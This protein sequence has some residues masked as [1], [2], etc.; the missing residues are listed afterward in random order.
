MLIIRKL[1]CKYG[2]S[3]GN[4]TICIILIEFSRYYAQFKRLR[5][6]K[7]YKFVAFYEFS[8]DKLYFLQYNII[9]ERNKLFIK[10]FIFKGRNRYEK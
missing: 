2:I 8:L 7:A 10:R 3:R 5:F 4:I 1:L 9:I 6:I